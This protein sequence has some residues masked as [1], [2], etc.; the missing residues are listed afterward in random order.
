M[1]PGPARGL[2]RDGDQ[3]Q[4]LWLAWMQEEGTF[5]L[6]D[7]TRCIACHPVGGRRRVKQRHYHRIVKL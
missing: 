5:F 6:K 3:A 7:A 4:S 1:R 2:V